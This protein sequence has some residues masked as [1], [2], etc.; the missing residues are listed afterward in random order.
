[1]SLRKEKGK[2][3]DKKKKNK[4]G[5]KGGKE[6]FSSNV[7]RVRKPP[8]EVEDRWKKVPR[9]RGKPMFSLPAVPKEV[10]EK[11]T[12]GDGISSEQANKFVSKIQKKKTLVREQKVKWAE[13]VAARAELLLTEEPGFLQANEGEVTKKL[14]Q[15]QIAAHVDITSATKYFELDLDFGPY[16]I[17][18]TRNGR[19]LLIGGRRG[20]VGAFDWV[21]K[22]LH[23]EIN[24]MEEIKDVQWLHIETMFAI[25]QK[26]WVHIYNNQGV[27]IH[28]LQNMKNVLRMT[29][30]PYHFLLATS[31]EDSEV[32]C[33]IRHPCD[34]FGFTG[35]V[36][37]WCPTKKKALVNMLCHKSGVETLSVDHTG[38]YMATTSVSRELKI[39]DIRKLE[40][41]PVQIYDLRGTP[42]DTSFSQRGGLALG[43]NNCVEVY[44][45]WQVVRK[46]RA[47]L[48]HESLGMIDN[49]EFC[50][51]E[52][53]LGIGTRTGFTSI[54]V[55][56]SGEPNFD[57]FEANPM[58][59]KSQRR[60]AEVKSLLD[61]VQPEMIVLEPR[62]LLNVNVPKLKERIQTK[63]DILKIRPPDVDFTPKNKKRGNTARKARVKKIVKQ[64]MKKDMARQI[65]AAQNQILEKSGAE[66]PHSKKQRTS[67]A[68]SRF[69]PKNKK[70]DK[71]LQSHAKRRGV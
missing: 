9:R 22:R 14:T 28:C 60:E 39:W 13:E 31:N 70:K 48:V 40:G 69:L 47:Y 26:N 63:I 34:G 56:G 44:R 51:Y 43:F 62:D 24:V 41:S 2:K 37:M 19:H 71:S 7:Q 53:V 6:K 25:A 55:P 58:Q 5:P 64:D 59:T 65:A 29:F 16:R 49:V 45:D 46:K 33:H 50:P 66:Q 36:S 4:N 21:T 67:G 52:D 27:E 18:Y 3:S 61:K 12:R 11:H 15:R 38:T 30:L 42:V 10:A 1:M 23:C 20:H 32:P 57:A 35:T 17:D 54:I 8:T 68:L